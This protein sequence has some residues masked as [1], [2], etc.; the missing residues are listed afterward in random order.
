MIITTKPKSNYSY[1][2]N[3]VQIV[4]PLDVGI[5]IPESSE[6]VS[7]LEVMKGIDLNRYF[8]FKME[9]R[10]RN[11]YDKTHLF[12]TVLFAYMINVRSLRDIEKM[13]QYDIRFMHLMDGKTPSFMGFERLEKDYLSHSYDDIFFDVSKRIGDMM[14]IDYSISYTDGT[15][16]EA[17]AIRTHLSIISALSIR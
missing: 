5:I 2:Y 13:C 9:T 8:E 7:F 15:K 1:Y 4:L 10:G 16:I 6:V 11:G 12:R 3:A 17:N 14:N